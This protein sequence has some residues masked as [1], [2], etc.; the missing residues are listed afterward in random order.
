M[1]TTVNAYAT[2]AAKA[3]F[4]KTTIERRDLK[5]A[6]VLIDIKFAGICH[7]DIHTAREEWGS[8]NFP[9]VPGHE[10]AGIVSEVGP[11][12]TKYKVGDRV[13]VGCMVDSVRLLMFGTG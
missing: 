10:I 2:S 11:E 3:P 5:P 13:G 7:S 4:E 6:D 9:L 1:P 12:V 8:T